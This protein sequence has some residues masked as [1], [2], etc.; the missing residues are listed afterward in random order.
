MQR[1]ILH[2]DLDAFFCSVEENNDPALR[3]KAFAVGGRPDQRGVVASCS[4][5]ARLR[6]I[7]SAM[8]MAQALK[9]QPD[10]IIVS[11]RHSDYGKISHQIMDYLDTLTPLIEQVSIDEAFLDLSDL[12]DSA[13]SL[14]SAIQE[15]IRLNFHL[16]CSIGV[17]TSKL[18][19]KIATDVG[20][21]SKRSNMPPQAIKVVNPGEEAAFLAP[22]PTKALWGIG[23]KTAERLDELGI[24]TIGDIARTP[25]TEL[26]KHLGK[27]G[28]DLGRRAIGIDDSPVHTS[29]TVKSVSNETTFA[30]DVSDIQ[31]LYETLHSLSESVGRR[32]R[33]KN[34]KGT[35]VKLKLRWSDFITLTR[36][37]TLDYPTNDDRDIYSSVKEIFNKTWVKGKP[38]RLLGVGLTQFE[39]PAKQLGLWDAPQKSNNKLF[40]AVD[41]VRNRYGKDSIMRLSDLKYKKPSETEIDEAENE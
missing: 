31:I 37:A 27:F 15:Y 24:R 41:D 12:P 26:I 11:G 30:R 19:A 18:V 40:T 3:G 29:H 39:N 35:T 4:Y 8:P 25:K 17:A 7:H 2:I 10:L 22:L 1:K 13:E 9:L 20:K 32:L 34:L 36:Q 16:P 33:K 5:A 28:E 6:G 38:V 21:A 14:A 23:P